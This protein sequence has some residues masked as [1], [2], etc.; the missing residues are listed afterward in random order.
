MIMNDNYFDFCLKE[1]LKKNKSREK[2]PLSGTGR[3]RSLIDNRHFLLVS[4][5][6]KLLLKGKSIIIMIILGLRFA[7]SQAEVNDTKQYL[8]LSLLTNK[9]HY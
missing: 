4:K 8:S 7:F 9:N 2:I 6:K 3:S 5:K 1:N